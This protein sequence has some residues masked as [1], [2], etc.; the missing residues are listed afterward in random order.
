V[1]E[2]VIK[3]YIEQDIWQ[4]KENSNTQY[5][6]AG[7]QLM[8]AEL[9][10]KKYMLDEVFPSKI[11]KAYDDGYIH[12][13]D[14]GAGLVVYCMGHD[15]QEMLE[16]GL[17]GVDGKISTLPPRHL[18]S[19]INQMV[20]YLFTLQADAAGAQAFNSIDTLLAP[21]IKM[22]NLSYKEVKQC[23]QEFI[24]P[25]NIPT[26]VGMQSPFSNC[27][28]DLKC[29]E[30]FKA[31]H[32]K[33]CGKA[34]DFTYGDC[35]NEIGMIAKAFFDIMSDG[36][37]RGRPFTFPIP[38]INL[39]KNFVWDDEVAKYIFEATAKY[40]TPS[41]QNFLNSDLDPESQ[42]SMCCRLRI[43][44]SQLIKASGGTFGAG[45]KTGSIGVVTLNLPR[46]AYEAK[47]EK[48]LLESIEKY[49][50][51]AKESLEIKRELISKNLER[52]LMPYI[53][54]YIG[55]FKN[56]FSTV[57]LVGGNEMCLNL[58]GKDITTDDGQALMERVLKFL[59]AQV[60]RFQ[61][62]TGNLYNMEQSPSESTA[63]K[64]AK[65]D[66]QVHP[67]I[68][69]AGNG[70]PYYT[71]SSHV[72]VENKISLYK[73]LKLQDKFNKYYNGGTVVHVFLGQRVTDWIN[74][75]MLVKKIA[76]A[77]TLPF[78]T[79]TPN[80]S[81]CPIHGYIAGTHEMCPLNHT[82]A[83]LKEYGILE[84]KKMEET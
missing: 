82:E 34:L 12:I 81:I 69:A 65:Y 64:L 84:T 56:H 58:I 73:M 3:D 62:E 19:A 16:L 79:I 24:Y 22:E 51:I 38:T 23:M 4:V 42:Y 77:T 54:R 68:I 18:R 57:G 71:N 75:M 44:K 60:A 66:K 32:P 78:F 29:P 52:G 30:R 8:L 33:I 14:L 10:V 70:T 11:K 25:L 53:K 28:F 1:T 39:H 40:G 7:L 6:Y 15:L 83:E 76:E 63:Y 46:L 50:I 49:A 9:S 41:F 17:N 21:Y 35:N 31:L 48:E 27:T 55:T 72:H 67:K 47:N 61:E 59:Q 36:D 43:D 26:R 37:A 80:F 5:S 13:H 45:N 74:C 2:N 20:N